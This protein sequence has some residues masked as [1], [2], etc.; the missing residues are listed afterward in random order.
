MSFAY[1]LYRLTSTEY[2]QTVKNHLFPKFVTTNFGSQLR[3]LKIGFL[4][5]N[6]GMNQKLNFYPGKMDS[7]KESEINFIKH[8]LIY[9]DAK[10]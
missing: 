9:C 4:R 7:Q 1:L 2:F 6:Q 5:T 3:N 8:K 10:L